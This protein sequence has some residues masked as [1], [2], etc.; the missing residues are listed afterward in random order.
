MEKHLRASKSAALSPDPQPDE[1]EP[2]VTSDLYSA[3][4]CL[5]AGFSVTLIPVSPS[6]Y[7]FACN[8]QA[9]VAAYEYF[10]GGLVPARLY[11]G[12]LT[13]LETLMHSSR[14]M[15]P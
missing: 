7:K 11:A 15:R 1:P 12:A 4:A 14:E 13:D 6:K 3:A 2:F 9:Q 5:A 8:P 10:H